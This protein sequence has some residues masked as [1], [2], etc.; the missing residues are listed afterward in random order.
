MKPL[1]T[2]HA[3][4]YLVGSYIEEH[5]KKWNVWVPS[6]DT[7]IDLLV[8][9]TQN[10]RAVSFQIKFSKDF[11]PTHPTKLLQQKLMASGW[12]T[13][14]E[15][16]IKESKADFWV[17]VLPSFTEHHTSFII[18]TPAELLRRLRA[19]H[20]G[21][22]K[23]LN[24]YLWVTK[25]QRCWESRGLKKA[26]KEKIAIDQFNHT[27]RDFT[28]FLDKKGWVKVERRLQKKAAK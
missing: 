13:P 15:K 7:G 25:K 5:Y 10:A 24:S 19:I 3:G 1:F 23:K 4:E 12:W 22:G 27:T 26:D 14:Q 11:T 18:I 16:K 17:F 20:G 2:V 9:D 8:T 28:Q 21:V 6:K